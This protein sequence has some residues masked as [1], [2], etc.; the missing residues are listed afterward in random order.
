VVISFTQGFLPTVLLALLFMLV[1][2]ALR[3]LA[4]LEGIPQKTGV[5][6]SLMNRFFLFQGIVHGHYTVICQIPN[7]KSERFPGC[8]PLLIA[9]SRRDTTLLGS[10]PRSVQQVLSPHVD[11]GKPLSYDISTSRDHARL[12]Y[13]IPHHQWPPRVC[14]LLLILF[15]LQLSINDQP[16]SSDT[17]GLF[18][19]KAIQHLFVGLYVQ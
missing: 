17:G 11:L 10:I 8:H 13:Y 5:E 9:I 12:L 6:L 16:R 18:F 2:I 4:R 15:P 1:P 19:P 7:I 14:R 3:I